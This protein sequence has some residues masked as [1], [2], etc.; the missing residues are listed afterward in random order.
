MTD[1]SNAPA[2]GGIQSGEVASRSGDSDGMTAALALNAVPT[3]TDVARAAR[4]DSAAFERLYRA[5]LPRVTS[6]ARWLLGTDDVDDAV[7]DVFVRVWEKLDTFQGD[8][9]FGTWLHRVAVN[10]LLRRRQRRAV[11]WSRHVASEPAMEA[12]A[13]PV[14]RPE[15]RIALEGAV[16]TLPAGAREV[17]VLHDMEGYKHDEIATQLGIDPGTSRSQLHRARALLRKQLQG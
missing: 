1:R 8:A 16:S 5:H 6:L 14:R 13:G 15:L 4:G 17:F 11:Q 12:V 3:Q 7:Q 2:D 9:A 10:L